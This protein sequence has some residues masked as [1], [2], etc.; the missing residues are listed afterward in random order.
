MTRDKSTPPL[1]PVDSKNSVDAEYIRALHSAL[2]SKRATYD[3]MLWQAPMISLTAQA[4]LLTI[5][6]SDDRLYFYRIVSGLAATFI[7]L[8]SWQLFIRHSAME[9]QASKKLEDLEEKYFP[10]KA[11]CRPDQESSFWADIPSK[12]IW[13]AC[14]LIISSIGLFPLFELLCK[15]L[16]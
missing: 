9:L 15:V 4:F 13:C 12:P 10:Q 14:L 5:A 16:F 2:A 6:F 11:H 1:P 8:A 3:L 7:G